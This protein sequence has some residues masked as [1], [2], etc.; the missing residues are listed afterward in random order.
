MSEEEAQIVP[1]TTE[2]TPAATS[3]ETPAETPAA[4]S[5]ETP[6]ETPAATSDETP[7]ATDDQPAVTEVTEVTVTEDAP[8]D[9]AATPK[10]G[11]K[12]PKEE[13]I[14]EVPKDEKK[15]EGNSVY[16]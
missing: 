8:T 16:L 4:T 14:E 5:E 7:A 13:M 11:E 10:D 1:P 6:A 12:P 15:K 3:E 2:E 9:E